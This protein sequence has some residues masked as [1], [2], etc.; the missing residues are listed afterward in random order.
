MMTP[1]YCNIGAIPYSGQSGAVAQPGFGS[2]VGIAGLGDRS[3]PAWSRDRALVMVLGDAEA[4]PIDERGNVDVLRHL[5]KY[6]IC[7]CTEL[8]VF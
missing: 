7:N 5:M 3:P 8:E 4:P 1:G 2:R 6:V